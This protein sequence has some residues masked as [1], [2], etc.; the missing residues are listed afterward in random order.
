[1]IF[2]KAA[3]KLFVWTLYYHNSKL[4]IEIKLKWIRLLVSSNYTFIIS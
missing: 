3:G 2:L 1:M 4:R